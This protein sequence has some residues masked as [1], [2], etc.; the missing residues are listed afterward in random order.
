MV[1][2]P[3]A[4]WKLGRYHLSVGYNRPTMYSLQADVES[5]VCER[6]DLVRVAHDI[7]EWGAACG[8]LVSV[9]GD[10]KTVGIQGTVDLESGKTYQL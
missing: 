2:D 4:A 10:G 9:S 3:D 1:T 6:G 7:T 8:R 5:M